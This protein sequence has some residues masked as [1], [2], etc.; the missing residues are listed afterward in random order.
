V[1]GSVGRF[2]A[3][4]A[5]DLDFTPVVRTPQALEKFKP[6]DQPLRARLR[7]QLGVDVSKGEELTAPATLEELSNPALIGSK[8]DGSDKL[9]RRILILTEGKQAGGAFPIQDIRRKILE[10]YSGEDRSRGRHVLSLGNDLARYYRTVCIEYKSKVEGRDEK[11]G[12]R[13]MKLRHNRKFW[14]FS[15]VLTVV[16]LAETNPQGD[17]P[18]IRGLLEAFDRPPFQRLFDAVGERLQGMAGRVVEPFAWFIEFTSDKERRAALEAV[19]WDTRYEMKLDN[20]FHAAKFNSG[21][22]KD[23]HAGIGADTRHGVSTGRRAAAT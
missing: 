9:T 22:T 7:D 15:C 18:Y 1:V 19:L 13:N 2:E 5:S 12:I 14:F 21:K 17:E 3:L 16:H 23:C 20:P 6:H 4:Q 10:A 8:E 11:W